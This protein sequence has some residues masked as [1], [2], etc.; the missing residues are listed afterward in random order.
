MKNQWIKQ[1]SWVGDQYVVGKIRGVVMSFHGLG[2]G[3]RGEPGTLELEWARAGGL[4]VY[5]YTG[6]W[7][8]M[9]R[10]SREMVDKLI[11]RIY[12]EFKLPAS[13]PLINTGGS[14]GG[15]ATLLYT[16]YAKRPVA[17]CV[18]FC[19]VCDLKYHFNERPDL[20]PTIL[21]SL[22]Y[23]EGKEL[24]RLIE[25]NSPLAQVAHMPKIPYLFQHGDKDLA[26]SKKY[27]SD[28]MVAAM[29]ARKLKVQYTQVPG[30][31]HGNL[32]PLSVNVEQVEFVRKFLK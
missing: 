19:P 29:R 14:M 17:A 7:S 20:P 4:V 18:A 9:N 30:M 5:P 21:H 31:G 2:G 23:A 27:H 11:D 6:P 32:M 8:W 25:E 10:T 3:L 16:R 24:A 12:A 15:L 1:V 22:G 13:T 26:V 28:K